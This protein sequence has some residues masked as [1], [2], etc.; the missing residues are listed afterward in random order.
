MYGDQSGEAVCRY[1]GPVLTESLAVCYDN[2]MN[3]NLYPQ[4]IQ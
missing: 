2:D 1:W 3:F 4:N